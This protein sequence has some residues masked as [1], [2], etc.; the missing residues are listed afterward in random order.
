MEDSTNFLNHFASL[1]RKADS[2]SPFI[3]GW[4]ELR[5]NIQLRSV[6]VEQEI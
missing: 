3:A 5:R 1:S 2:S 4:L 6:D